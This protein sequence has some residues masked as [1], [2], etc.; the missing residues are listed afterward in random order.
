MDTFV[1][2]LMNS[3][4]LEVCLENELCVSDTWF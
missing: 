4:L 1:G 3:M 2:I